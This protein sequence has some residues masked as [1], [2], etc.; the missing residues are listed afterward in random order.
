MFI[1]YKKLIRSKYSTLRALSTISQID[2]LLFSLTYALYFVLREINFFQQTT[3]H[4]I[5]NVW[6]AKLF[7]MVFFWTWRLSILLFKYLALSKHLSQQWLFI[8]TFILGCLAFLG[9]I[10]LKWFKILLDLLNFFAIFYQPLNIV[11]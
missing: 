3:I 1:H 10:H 9:F 7:F 6:H 4:I 8:M 11:F 5:R 2:F